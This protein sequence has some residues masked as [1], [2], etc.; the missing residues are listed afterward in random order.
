MMGCDGWYL[1][2]NDLGFS[3]VSLCSESFNDAV[4]ESKQLIENKLNSL[5]EEYNLSINDD[6]KIQIVRYL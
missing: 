2:C 3:Q 5:L 4:T 1:T 6:S